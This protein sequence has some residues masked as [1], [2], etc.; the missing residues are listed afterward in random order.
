[1]VYSQKLWQQVIKQ[2]TV[3]LNI[4][5]FKI[6]RQGISTSPM[7]VMSNRVIITADYC[8]NTSWDKESTKVRAIKIGATQGELAV[9]FLIT[10]RRSKL[11]QHYVN[12]QIELWLIKEKST[13]FTRRNINLSAFYF[14]NT[15]VFSSYRKK[16]ERKREILN[17]LL[18]QMVLVVIL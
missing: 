17:T 10:L 3:I 4:A 6:Y 13:R 5:N 8:S 7:L 2:N 14:K 18:A 12:S 11:S 16:K 1:M 9:S 15:E